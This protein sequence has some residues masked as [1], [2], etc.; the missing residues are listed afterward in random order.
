VVEMVEIRSNG[1]K[2]CGPRAVPSCAKLPGIH[3]IYI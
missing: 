2:A 3:V 1:A